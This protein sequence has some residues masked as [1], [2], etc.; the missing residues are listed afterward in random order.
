MR[1]N[2]VPALT[3]LFVLVCCGSALL[4]IAAGCSSAKTGPKLVPVE[5]K[6]TVGGK[7]LPRGFVILFPDGQAGNQSNEE[8]RGTIES[9]GSYRVQ[10]HIKDGAPLGW[11]R[12]TVTAAEQIDPKNPYFT[13]W[14][15]PTKYVDPKTSKL[16]YEVVENPSPGRYDIKLDPLTK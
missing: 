16:R 8:P 1:A 10:T 11:Y 2:T 7:P 12:V 15:I 4:T 13:N 14:L 3:R 9:D 6:V 5:G